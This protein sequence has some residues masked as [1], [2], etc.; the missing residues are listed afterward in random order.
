M[1]GKEEGKREKYEET[2]CLLSLMVLNDNFEK[3][4]SYHFK[5]FFLW[6]LF[7]GHRLSS[8]HL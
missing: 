4:E 8:I 3:Y 7:L 5:E 1:G 2:I 6:E